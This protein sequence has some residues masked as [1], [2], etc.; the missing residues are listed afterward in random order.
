VTW[1]AAGDA[2]AGRYCQVVIWIPSPPGLGPG[3]D[4]IR[5]TE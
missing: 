2:G 3:I 4:V 5:T 1:K